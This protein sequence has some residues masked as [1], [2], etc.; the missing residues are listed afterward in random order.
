MFGLPPPEPL[1]EGRD[2]I[3]ENELL[4]FTREYLLQRACCGNGCRNCPY[5][6]NPCSVTP[7]DGP[8]PV[9]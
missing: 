4:V 2:Y 9:K 3:M 7:I 1:V 5:G 6:M 8:F